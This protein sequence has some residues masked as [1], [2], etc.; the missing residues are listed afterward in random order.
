[1][2]PLSPRSISSIVTS[3][4]EISSLGKSLLILVSTNSVS[5]RTVAAITKITIIRREA[6]MMMG[7][8]AAF[9]LF[10]LFLVLCEMRA[11]FRCLIMIF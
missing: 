7:D 5:L 9:L 2:V 1:M 8:L 11:R 4:R 3:A 6:F 10:V